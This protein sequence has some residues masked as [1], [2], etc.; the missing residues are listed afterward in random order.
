MSITQ[1]R[2]QNWKAHKRTGINTE[3]EDKAKR[4]YCQANLSEP[5]PSK[6]IPI[7]MPGRREMQIVDFNSRPWCQLW[8][9]PALLHTAVLSFFNCFPS[10]VNQLFMHFCA[11][12]PWSKEKTS[13]L[14]L[15]S[16][17]TEVVPSQRALLWC[18]SWSNVLRECSQLL[19]S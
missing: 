16:A 2:R 1:G 3:M 8:N 9:L 6:D 15:N 4:N 17:C 12:C 13:R 11:Q 10:D 7:G 14:A 19:L 5:S 18:T